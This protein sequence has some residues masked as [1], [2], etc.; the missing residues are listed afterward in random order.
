MQVSAATEEDISHIREIY[1][2]YVKNT[3]STY[4]EETPSVQTMT[5][6]WQDSL[7]F[8]Y[9]SPDQLIEGLE[10]GIQGLREGAE[11]KLIIPSHLAFG[12]EGSSSGIVPPYEP[13]LYEVKILSVIP[14][15]I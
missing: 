3:F 14:Q 6:R 5:E 13:I 12:K 15:D 9:G 2:Y 7:K 1:D 10:L 11:A 4:E 8:V